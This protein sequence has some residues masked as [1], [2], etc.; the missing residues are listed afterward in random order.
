MGGCGGKGAHRQ[1]RDS[2]ELGDGFHYSR[3]DPEQE[4]TVKESD[5]HPDIIQFAAPIF[6]AKEGAEFN[7]KL[8]RLGSLSGQVRCTFRTED[9]SGKAGSRYVHT[10]GQVIFQ[11]GQY[12]QSIPVEVL[13]T[14]GWMA[15]LEF[16]VVLENPVGCH[17][18]RY[19]NICRVKV[20]DTDYFPSSTYER[21][22]QKGED[23]IR[24]M[25]RI[26]LFAEFVKLL[27]S[28]PGVKWRLVLTLF[29]DQLK[30]VYAWFML[31]SSVY[32][33]NVI[34]NKDEALEQELVIPDNPEMTARLI[35]LMYVLAPLLLHCW[36]EA[37]LQMD[38]RGHCTLFLQTSVMRKYM[39]YSD[40][41]RSEVSQ[42]EVQKFV[43]ETSDE[44][45]Q[46]IDDI[47]SLSENL[48]KLIVLNYFAVSSDPGVAWAAIAMPVIMALWAF[49]REGL[50]H[51]PEETDDSQKLVGD[52]VS[53]ISHN[54]RLIAGY[55]QRPAMNDKFAARA[56]KLS[57]VRLP[58]VAYE[59]RSEF[60]FD[61]LG[62]LFVGGYVAFY[63]H[64]VL[65]GH[66]SLGTFLATISV[67]KEVGHN[68]A[69]GFARIRRVAAKF[70][71]LV[72]LTVFLNRATDVQELGELIDSRVRETSILR[73][74]ILSTPASEDSSAVRTDLIPVRLENL[75]FCFQGRHL[76][77]GVNISVPQGKLVAVV[78]RAGSGKTRLIRALG[79]DTSP[80]TGRVL[81]P[82]HL[83][84]LLVSHQVFLMNTSPLQNLFFGDPASLAVPEERRRMI[85]IL[86]KLEM[87]QTR[88]FAEREMQML[89][90]PSPVKEQEG[91]CCCW[92]A[93]PEDDELQPS[94]L[95]S[96]GSASA[97]RIASELHGWQESLSFQE[98][99]KLHIARALIMNPE[100]LILE[101]PLMNFDDYEAESVV[102]ALR[103][104]I[105][106]RG[107]ELPAET[108]NRRRPRT[109]FYSVERVSKND[110]PD[111]VWKLQNGEMVEEKEIP[112]ELP[113]ILSLLV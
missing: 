83:R 110:H 1:S 18:G 2:R 31:V 60:F 24:K 12:E 96:D 67:F 76:L 26:L 111:V 90:E 50:L 109:C 80:T 4:D 68:F 102:R 46:S 35:A 57:E 25:N 53:E 17:L 82:S 104:H 86:N 88:K 98:R 21:I 107:I 13:D 39:N 73:K 8:M 30:T 65:S 42:H 6:V 69:D 97:L 51:K 54:Y 9:C 28:V 78:G 70:S 85:K 108:R 66:L 49:L 5:D 62:P 11:P 72:D 36:R 89:Q 32:M 27:L 34:F 74:D 99:A 15:T 58:W 41:S 47:S 16:K 44:L 75:S 100:I 113:S 95:P 106:N 56:T 43:I 45:A 87:R 91:V 61:W 64:L 81:I 77:Q 63:S 105:S 93:L 103:E 55:F 29:F 59:L 92:D 23:D 84:C 101:K 94:W 14:P 33:V 38:I 7:V 48:G 79:S 37:K 40:S 19:L 3:I 52:M 10:E 71:P 22:L 20:L 112:T